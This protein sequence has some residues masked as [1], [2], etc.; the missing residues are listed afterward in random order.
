[1]TTIDV[2]YIAKLA[3]LPMSEDALQKLEGELTATLKH[4]ER[5]SDIDTSRV[6]GTN[7]VI[8]AVNVMREDI[9]QPSLTQAEALMNAKHVHNGFFVVPVIIEEAVE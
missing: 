7:E 6:E 8:D 9:A 3:E 4:V 2:K 1:M 5:L